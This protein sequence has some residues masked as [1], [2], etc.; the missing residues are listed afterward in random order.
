MTTERDVTRIVR[1]WLGTDAD[2]SADHI[3]DIVLDELDA[4][5]QRRSWWPAR[6]VPEMST[7]AKL[8]IGLAA[9]AVVAV[10]GAAL[11]AVRESD[12]PAATPSP[13]PTAVP[14]PSVSTV[15]PSPIAS[16]DPTR[17]SPSTGAPSAFPI[18]TYSATV[19]GI[20]FTFSLDSDWESHPFYR[21][22]STVGPQGAEAIIFWTT[23]PSAV[24]HIPCLDLLGRSVQSGSRTD[25]GRTIVSVAG[26]KVVVG[27][28]DTM[29]GGRA[30]TF[31]ELRVTNQILD[32][33]SVCQPGLFY[34]WPPDD[35]GGAMWDLTLPDDTVLVWIVDIDEKLLW[36]QAQ[37]H[38]TAGPGYER[39]I[40]RF[41]DSIAFK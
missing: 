10:V 41:V 6:S 5:P 37:T 27:P 7:Y 39:E 30:A 11:M 19:G 34:R 18:A 36:I 8:P 25:L 2:V 21:S 3:L 15:A 12:G 28:L 17:P 33:A 31:V 16:A 9:V 35:A 29:V 4:T 38:V 40:R 32:N 24:D 13:G 1:S 26:T 20:A 22:K 23:P 14:S